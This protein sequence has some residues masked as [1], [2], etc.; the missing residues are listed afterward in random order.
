MQDKALTSFAWPIY[1]TNTAY[2]QQLT[3]EIRQSVEYLIPS[4]N[5]MELVWR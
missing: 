5:I 3:S 2:K 4:G 1:R